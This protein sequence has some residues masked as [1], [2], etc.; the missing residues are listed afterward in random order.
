M[1]KIG[2]PRKVR[3]HILPHHLVLIMIIEVATPR[4][5]Q[6][7]AHKRL[8]RILI[9]LRSRIEDFSEAFPQAVD[10]DGLGVKPGASD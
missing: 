4:T 3:L 10:P 7:M 2:W 1:R 8:L 9:N 6:L 5:R